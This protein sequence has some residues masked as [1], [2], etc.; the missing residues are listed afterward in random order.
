M[1]LYEAARAVSFLRLHPRKGPNG[2]LYVGVTNDLARRMTDHKAKLVPGFT[3][4]YGV[5]KLVYVEEYAPSSKRAPAHPQALA[6]RM[7]DRIDRKGKPGLARLERADRVKVD[8]S[9]PGRTAARSAAKRCC[10]EPGPTFTGP[11]RCGAPSGAHAA[12]RPRTR[13]VVRDS[14]LLPGAAATTTSSTGNFAGRLPA[15]YN[16][17]VEVCDRWAAAEPGRHCADRCAARRALRRDQLRLRCATPRTG[18]PMRLRA[19]GIGRGDRVAIL[20]PQAPEVAAIHIAIYKLAAVALPLAILFGVDALSYRLQQFRRQGAGDQRARVSP[21]SPRS[22]ATCP[23][24]R[25][26]SRSTARATARSASTTRLRARVAGVHAGAHGGRRS[27]A[28][29]LHLGHHRPAE[30][31]AARPPRAARPSARHRVAARVPAAAGRPLW[32]PADWAWAGGLLDC[33][34]PGLYYGV[35][36]VA[37][38]VRASSTPRR[39]SP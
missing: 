35:P 5:D 33:L 6:A 28:D 16:I 39:P 32:T 26:C 20:L 24:S 15:T 29:D 21:S 38:R 2:T 25:S 9:R 18:S 19:H 30:G 27:R 31:R 17:G 23:T 7:E 3:R 10:A 11:G 22:A 1:R 36:V 37:R 34:L 14:S 13:G 8:A 4:K 12:P